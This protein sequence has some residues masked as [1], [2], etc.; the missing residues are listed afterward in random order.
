MSD[1]RLLEGVEV[2]VR[3]SN[4]TTAE[5]L[6]YVGEVDQRRLYRRE[7]CS[8]MFAFCVERLHSV[9]ERGGPADHGGADGAAVSGGARDDRAGEIHLTAVNLLGPHLTEENHAGLLA[10]ARHAGKR[11]SRGWSPRSRHDRTWR[12][13]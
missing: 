5:L 2:L 1:D 9:G 11:R 10:R 7:A 8:S 13:A 3:R 12:R 4:E 6:G